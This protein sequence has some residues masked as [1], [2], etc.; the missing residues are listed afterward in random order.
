MPWVLPQGAGIRATVCGIER[1]RARLSRTIFLDTVSGRR[2]PSL[3]G[4]RPQ[5]IETQDF[6]AVL[7]P[8]FLENLIIRRELLPEVTIQSMLARMWA[9]GIE[10]TCCGFKFG[11]GFIYYKCEWHA[12][13]ERWELTF[14]S[15]TPGRKFHTLNNTHAVEVQP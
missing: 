1:S 8:H 10:D 13:R 5:Y 9:V 2:Y 6:V 15:F 11:Q 3:I 14:I 4:M 7:T 12:K